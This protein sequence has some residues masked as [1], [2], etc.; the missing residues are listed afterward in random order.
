MILT[1]DAG[2]DR[3]KYKVVR[4]DTYEEI[5][6]DAT[7]VES[8]DE[9]GVCV[10]LIPTLDENG[11]VKKDSNGVVMLTEQRYDLSNCGGIRTIRR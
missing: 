2:D 4:C 10:L 1:R 8:S 6:K 3:L 5:V 9:T 11:F 7:V